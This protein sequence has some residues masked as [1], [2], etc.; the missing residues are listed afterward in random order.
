VWLPKC[1]L[2]G[3]DSAC[4][5]DVDCS[6]WKFFFESWLWLS[7][8]YITWHCLYGGQTTK[9]L[10]FNHNSACCNWQYWHSKGRHLPHHACTISN[11]IVPNHHK[12]LDYRCMQGLKLHEC[13]ACSLLE[14]SNFCSSGLHGFLMVYISIFRLWAKLAQPR[15]ASAAPPV[16]YHWANYSASGPSIIWPLSNQIFGYLNCSS[17]CSIRG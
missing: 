7:T 11:L 15:Y 10:W 16:A 12:K 5:Q 2:S 4:S 14:V 9:D 3:Y 1:V 13:W 6:N 8:N 17:D